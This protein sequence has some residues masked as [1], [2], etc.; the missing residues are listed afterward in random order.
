MCNP[1][2]DVMN[3]INT[4]IHQMIRVV[5]NKDFKQIVLNDLQDNDSTITKKEYATA[6]KALEKFAIGVEKVMVSCLQSEVI[7]VDPHNSDYYQWGKN[8]RKLK[9]DEATAKNC[10]ESFNDEIKHANKD[11]DTFWEGYFNEA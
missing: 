3:L 5:N 10:I 4:T 11:I 9:Y 2:R 6:K 1:E 8:C 7:P